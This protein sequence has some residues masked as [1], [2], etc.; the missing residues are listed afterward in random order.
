MRIILALTLLSALATTPVV[1]QPVQNAKP[2]PKDATP[3]DQPSGPTQTLIKA[4]A[5][6]DQPASQAAARQLGVMGL[7]AIPALVQ[8]AKEKVPSQRLATAFAEMSPKHIPALADIIRND[9][10]ERVRQAVAQG[11]GLMGPAAVS[12][13]VTLAADE[14]K[15]VR[16]S[17]FEAL[18]SMSSDSKIPVPGKAVAVLVAGLKDEELIIRDFSA[19][20]LGRIGPKT[21]AVIPAL[22]TAIADDIDGRVR[23]RSAAALERIARYG[24]ATAKFSPALTKSLAQ[25]EEPTVRTAAADA[26]GALRKEDAADGVKALAAALSDKHGPVRESAAHALYE[27]GPPAAA[28][29]PQLQEVIA[30]DDWPKARWY[31]TGALGRLG[32]AAAPAVVTLGKALTDDNRDVQAAAAQS[33]SRLGSTAEPALESLVGALQNDQSVVREHA[34]TSLGNLGSKAE[35]ATE[36]LTALLDDKSPRVRNAAKFALSKIQKIQTKKQTN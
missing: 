34:A 30:N 18:D 10:D 14:D 4:L 16:L 11:L 26:L 15:Y 2:V 31:A 5:G 13:I 25:D 28:A 32:T 1:A 6:S 12:I 35:S 36:A 29:I 21:E 17:A 8:A 23:A 22:L 3:T 24:G 7:K 19:G 33:L 20:S 27:I 9:K